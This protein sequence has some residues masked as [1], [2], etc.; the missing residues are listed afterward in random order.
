M[1]GIK[2]K[3]VPNAY[4][5]LCF[6]SRFPKPWELTKAKFTFLL[7]S[8]NN[9]SIPECLVTFRLHEYTSNGKKKKKGK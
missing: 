6:F 7:H 8:S 3:P 4:I 5:Q 2:A 1:V 9:R